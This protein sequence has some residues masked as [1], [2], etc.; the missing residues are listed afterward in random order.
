M[1]F[2]ITYGAGTA[3]T[4]IICLLS[5]LEADPLEGIEVGPLVGV[6]MDGSVAD[7]PILGIVSLGGFAVDGP[8]VGWSIAG[9]APREAVDGLAVDR[10]IAN[11]S[12]GEAVP[13]I[14]MNKQNFIHTLHLYKLKANTT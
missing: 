11:I 10:L 1:K 2:I 3:S 9:E 4:D 6:P 13:C 12:T 8:A 5:M 14:T 7:G